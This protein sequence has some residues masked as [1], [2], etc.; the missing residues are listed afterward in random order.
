MG[1]P[2]NL[3]NNAMLSSS[4]IVVSNDRFH[5]HSMHKTMRNILLSRWHKNLVYQS[6]DV[7]LHIPSSTYAKWW[8]I[9]WAPTLEIF[10]KK[11]YYVDYR[12]PFFSWFWCLW[13]CAQILSFLHELVSCFLQV[14]S[15]YPLWFHVGLQFWAQICHCSMDPP[16]LREFATTGFEIW[17]SHRARETQILS[18][19]TICQTS[20]D[21]LTCL[22]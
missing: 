18:K 9:M 1:F 14:C 20:M 6:Y 13:L 3:G 11:L 19:K 15:L 8:C 5:W 12:W 21:P 10:I 16:T 17:N 7:C 22:D 4:S 2:R